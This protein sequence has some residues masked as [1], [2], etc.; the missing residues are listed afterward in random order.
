MSVEVRGGWLTRA[1]IWLR[2]LPARRRGTRSAGILFRASDME[3]GNFVLLSG[4]APREL[5]Y[6]LIGRFWKPKGDIVRF[7]P[8][9]FATF[10][11]AGVA[12]LAYGF[13]IE[14]I[15]P[16]RT[17]LST[18]TAIWCPDTATRRAMLAYWLLIRPISGL[19]RR[20]ILASVATV[21]TK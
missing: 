18:T 20:E 5:V 6:G 19:I 3:K 8:E 21:S 14:Q 15:D 17:R 9:E 10:D 4:Q 13:W 7:A 11:R 12:K 16:G 2:T 1:A